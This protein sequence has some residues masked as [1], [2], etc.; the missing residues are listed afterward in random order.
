MSEKKFDHIL[1]ERFVPPPSTNLSERIISAALNS[2]QTK[3]FWVV[4]IEQFLDMFVI[5]RPA[6]A[7]A[8]CILFGVVLGAQ[9]PLESEL[10]TQDYF[11]FLTY[12]EGDLL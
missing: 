4:C 7:L 8:F 11:S 6:Y 12:N 3:P 5:P 1:T 2:A 10:Y 9:I